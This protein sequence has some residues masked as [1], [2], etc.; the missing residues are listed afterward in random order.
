MKLYKLLFG[1]NKRKLKPIMID[2]YDKCDRYKKARENNVS[3]WHFIEPAEPGSKT[4][5]IDTA[6]VGGNKYEPGRNNGYIGKN[7]FNAHT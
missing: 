7:G 5:K 3:G 2:S 6:T 1:R 4:W